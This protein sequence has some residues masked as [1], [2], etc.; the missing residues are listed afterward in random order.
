MACIWVI[1]GLKMEYIQF[2]L[3]AQ[4]R[5]IGRKAGGVATKAYYRII[6]VRSFPIDISL[7]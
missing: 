2:L 4:K 1:Y 6:T 7:T 3:A 5:F